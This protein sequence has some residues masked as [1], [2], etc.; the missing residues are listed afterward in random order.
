MQNGLMVNG[1][2]NISNYSEKELQIMQE[3]IMNERMKLFVA[4]F[5]EMEN[6]INRANEKLEI[7]SAE[8]EN[9]ID[10]VKA[11]S[12]KK[13]EVTINKMRVDKNKWGF[14]AQRDIGNAFRVSIGSQTIGKLFRVVGLAI[15]SRTGNTEPKREYVGKYATT[16]IVNGYP[17]FRWHQENC[18]EYIDK[19]LRKMNLLEDF[20]SIET[21]KEMKNFI[22]GLYSKYV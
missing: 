3:A 17:T 22:D 6:S 7:V 21:E 19:W 2:F 20:Y 15:K 11:E 9:K 13:M 18:I 12:D 4:K 5:E 14:V 8:L 16:E 1:S 10:D